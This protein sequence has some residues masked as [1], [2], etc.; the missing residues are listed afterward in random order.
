MQI[1]NDDVVEEDERFTVQLSS[2]LEG[3]SVRLDP[4]VASIFII[5]ED[6]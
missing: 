2:R 5:D 1:I 4:K 3:S 6:G